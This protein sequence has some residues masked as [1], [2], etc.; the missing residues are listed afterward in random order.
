MSKLKF[1]EII[2]LICK[3]LIK[4]SPSYCGITTSLE[5]NTRMSLDD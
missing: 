2:E 1:H 4:D 5:K 3:K